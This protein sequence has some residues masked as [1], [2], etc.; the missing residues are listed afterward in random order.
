MDNHEN[1]KRRL[2]AYI[3]DK[4]AALEPSPRRNAPVILDE[5]VIAEFLC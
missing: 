5:C 1:L 2:D 4:L 3:A